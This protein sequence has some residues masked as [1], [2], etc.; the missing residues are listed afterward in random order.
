MFGTRTENTGCGRP[1]QSG[2]WRVGC[3]H[4]Q[5]VRSSRYGEHSMSADTTALATMKATRSRAHRHRIVCR[6]DN[7]HRRHTQ[8]KLAPDGWVETE[9]RCSRA[10]H[11]NDSVL[12]G[13]ISAMVH[14]VSAYGRSAQTSQLNIRFRDPMRTNC[15]AR[16]CGWIRQKG[17]RLD[18]VQSESGRLDVKISLVPDS[19]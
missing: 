16:V 12:H 11:G 7:S 6:P 2:S 18:V 5:Y 4:R 19:S 13:G 1:E 17:R 9:I 3:C 8:F 14:R 10:Y 15:P